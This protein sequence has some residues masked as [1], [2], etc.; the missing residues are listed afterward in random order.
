MIKTTIAVGLFFLVAPEQLRAQHVND[1]YAPATEVE[2]SLVVNSEHGGTV[3]LE[4]VRVPSFDLLIV[5]SDRQLTGAH[6]EAHRGA[7]FIFRDTLLAVAGSADLGAVA[8]KL[9]WPTFSDPQLGAEHW[10]WLIQQS[11]ILGSEVRLVENQSD[12]KGTPKMM[13]SDSSATGQI[14]PPAI[15][16]TPPR[17]SFYLWNGSSLYRA[18]TNAMDSMESPA[19]L[20]LDY[21]SGFDH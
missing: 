10:A 8:S 9:H 6:V 18:T 4:V 11:G 16:S 7:L 19:S 12:L 13:L 15:E 3:R 20:D 21:L 2:A 14:A 5:R 1:Q 17:L